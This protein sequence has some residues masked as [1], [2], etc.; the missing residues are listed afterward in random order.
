[1]L[2]RRGRVAL[3]LA[4]IA[5]VLVVPFGTISVRIDLPPAGSAVAPTVGLLGFVAGPL[6]YAWAAVATALVVTGVVWIA[7]RLV[8]GRRKPH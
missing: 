1:M 5:F 4:A 6:T 7:R 8:A 2:W 3:L